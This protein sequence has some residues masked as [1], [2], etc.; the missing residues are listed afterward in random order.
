MRIIVIIF[1]VLI[2]ISFGLG[3][4]V[5][6]KA[7][8][9]QMQS[10]SKRHRLSE[11]MRELMHDKITLTEIREGRNSNAVE[12][13]EFSIDCQVSMLWHQVDGASGSMRDQALQTLKIIKRYREQW[14]RNPV[15][16]VLASEDLPKEEI[17]ATAQEAVK[18][19]DGL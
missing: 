1:L 2:P 5:R 12:S 6:A 7:S 8:R 3:W 14:P 15:A 13:L 11:T 19:L 10:R 9:S 17:L 16:D 18:I 4:W